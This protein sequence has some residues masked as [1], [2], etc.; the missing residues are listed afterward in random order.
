VQLLKNAPDAVSEVVAV[1]KD[2]APR[3]ETEASL[4]IRS[5]LQ[6]PV[7]TAPDFFTTQG[8]F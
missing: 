6:P 7:E 3:A 2:A 1:T 8:R 5:N 4:G